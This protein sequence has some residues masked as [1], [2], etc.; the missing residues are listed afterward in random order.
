MTKYPTTAIFAVP[1]GTY[2]REGLSQSALR[3]GR[4]GSLPAA[5]PAINSTL[6][7]REVSYYSASSEGSQE[8][9]GAFEGSLYLAATDQSN[10]PIRSS[11]DAA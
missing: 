7:Q 2:E 11:V 9:K 5:F 10:M 6:P 1:T 3:P 4:E 8:G